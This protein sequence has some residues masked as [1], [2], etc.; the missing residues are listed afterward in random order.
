MNNKIEKKIKRKLR[1]KGKI[2]GTS[3]KPRMNIFRSNDHVYV[4]L[5]DDVKRV[6]ILSASDYKLK[7]KGTKTQISTEVGKNIAKQ[8]LKKGIKTIV[9]D[10]GGNKYHGRVKAI[11]DGAREGGLIF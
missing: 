9:F 1:M 10:R 4:Q 6:T 3:E 8:A 7:V 5:I 2:H 11:A